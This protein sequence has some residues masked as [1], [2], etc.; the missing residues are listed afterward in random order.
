MRELTLPC[1]QCVGCRLERSRQWAVRCVHEGQMHDWNTFVTLTYSKEN[2]PEWNSLNYRHF[3]LFMKRMRKRMGIPIRFFM[4]GEYGERE[5][6][7][8]YHA[9]L[10][11]VFF[12]DRYPWRISPSGHQLY[13]SPMLESLWDLGNA[14]I[15]DFCFDTA[16]YVA[17]Y[18]MKKV[19]GPEAESHYAK[20]D[21]LTGEIGAVTPEFIRMS[22]KP[23]IGATWFDKYN[24]EVYPHDRVVINGAKAKPPRYYDK[25]FETLSPYV[26]ESVEYDRYL[27]SLAVASDNTPDRLRVRE[28]VT[29]ARLSLKTRSLE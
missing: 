27:K 8:H 23:G 11:G 20:L 10:F 16:A 15:G 26:W 12:S 19:T 21:L 2:L 25:R 9:C 24:A 17:R 14:E 4:C 28:T 1:G 5:K 6:R 22:L 18:I 7:P 29:R 13:R 3:Q